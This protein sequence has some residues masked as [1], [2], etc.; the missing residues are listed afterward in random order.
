MPTSL[1]A[2]RDDAGRGA[3]VDPAADGLS[4]RQQQQLDALLGLLEA[5][6]HAPTA[7]RGRE[8]ATTRHVADSLAALELE[9]VRAATRIADLG[10][11][12]GF[13][14]VALAVALPCAEVSLVESQR[15]RCEFLHRLCAVARLENIDVICTRAEAWAAGRGCHDLVV[16]RALAPQPVV[17]EYAAPLLQVGGSLVDWRGR[18]SEA[19]EQAATRAAAE[20]GLRRV[21]VRRVVPFEGANDRHLHL[22]AKVEDTPDRFPRRS[23]MARK[24]P[25]GG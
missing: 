16:A 20:L 25:L 19:E 5:D 21:E 3:G 4:E 10:S 8:Q 23:G 9:P 13:P 14:G 1:L 24:R 7:I 15:R 2:M 12:A 17:L 11:G 22:F 18:R 6:E